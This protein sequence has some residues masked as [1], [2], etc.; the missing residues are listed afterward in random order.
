MPIY[1]YKCNKCENRFDVFQSI[2]G[3]NENLICP[4]CGE[5]KPER[6]FS[7]FGA[8]IGSSLPGSS[9]VCSSSGPFT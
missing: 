8:G 4:I 7:I 1:E 5:P 6:I 3:S 9:T 2:G